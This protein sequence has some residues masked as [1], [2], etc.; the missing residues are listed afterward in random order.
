M[1]DVQVCFSRG[2]AWYG[3]AIRWLTGSPVNHAFIAFRSTDFPNQRMAVQIDQ[4]GV[5]VVP[6]DGVVKD[7]ELVECYAPIGYEDELALTAQVGDSARGLMGEAY[8]WLGI[9]GFLIK[10]MVWRFL[11]RRIFN[12]LHRR[13]ELFCS[14]FVSTLLKRARRFVW[15]RGLHPASV[16]PGALRKMLLARPGQWRLDQVIR[17]GDLEV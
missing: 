17:H 10:L 7:D 6:F 8:D 14:E 11:G 3:R 12:P 2:R 5:V 1:F 15:A 4:R 16:S 9:W 13:G